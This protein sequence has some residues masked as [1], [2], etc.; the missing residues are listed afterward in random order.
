MRSIVIFFSPSI[1][2]SFKTSFARA[3]EASLPIN[4]AYA[5]TLISAP[6]SSLIFVFTSRREN[7]R[8][9]R[10]ARSLLS[11]TSSLLSR[12]ASR[13]RAAGYRSRGPTQ[14]V[15][16]TAPRGLYLLGRT[17]AR[18]YYLFMSVIKSV[19]CVE[20][21]FLRRLFPGYELYI[22][23]EKNVKVTVFLPEFLRRAVLDRAYKL[24]CELFARD[25]EHLR[26]RRLLDRA[27]S[28][29][30]HKVRL[31]ET[32]TAINKERVISFCGGFG[33]RPSRLRAQICYSGL[34]QNFSKVYFELRPI[35][36]AAS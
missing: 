20:K 3:S 34:S 23:Y 28:D 17:V 29:G 31:P 6:S 16:S 22:I 27:L 1:I 8:R 14:T 19:E 32:D 35:S 11:P 5:T 33:K 4:F 2:M 15:R 13:N 36:F 26:F 7:R 12:C 24:V 21:L 30:M 9:L 18:N 25:I 10:G